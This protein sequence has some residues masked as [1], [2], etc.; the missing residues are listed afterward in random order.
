MIRKLILFVSL[1]LLFSCEERIFLEST[2]DI[3]L[4]DGVYVLDASGYEFTK[5]VLSDSLRVYEL[6]SCGEAAQE[7][8]VLFNGTGGY[9]S[10]YLLNGADTVFA[11]STYVGPVNGDQNLKV[12]ALDVKQGDCFILEPPGE[13]PSVIDG[14]YGSLGYYDWQG[15]GEQILSDRLKE[16]GLTGIKYIIETH[17]DTDHYGGL[18]D[19]TS[20]ALFS[21]EAYLDNASPAL[22]GCGDTLRF[23]GGV[24]GVILRYGDVAGDTLTTENDRSVCLKLIYGDFDMIFTGDIGE[25]GENDILSTG[26]LNPAEQYEVLKVAH[27]G[28]KFSSSQTF[29]EAVLPLISVIS[30]GEGNTFGHPA[31]ETLGRLDATGSDILRTDEKSTIEIFTDGKSFQIVYRR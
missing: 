30:S 1:L 3:V 14:G 15:G 26:L 4:K 5:A 28:S 24:N 13:K 11:K 9:Y 19:I 12:T 16:K 25:A 23:G 22:P 7:P 27:H 18:L 20:D 29:L 10:L 17:H 31:E 8:A 21:F 2:P 6:V